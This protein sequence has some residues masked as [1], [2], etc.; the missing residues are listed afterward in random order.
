MQHDRNALIQAIQHFGSLSIAETKGRWRT[1]VGRCRRC[2]HSTQAGWPTR[3]SRAVGGPSTAVVRGA[4][5]EH[6][7]KN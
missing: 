6:Y 7:Y 3:R 5:A 1:D 2:A 4:R